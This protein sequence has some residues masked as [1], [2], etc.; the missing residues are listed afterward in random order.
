MVL[1]L[2]YEA[3][4]NTSPI[5]TCLLAATRD[6][7]I[8]AVNEAFI[9]NSGRRREDL[10]GLSVFAAFPGD[11]DDASD[12]GERAVRESLRRVLATGA[13][14]HLPVQR[15]PILVEHADGTSHYEER[16]WSAVSAPIFDTDG[17]VL[18]ITHSTTDIT[19]LVRIEAAAKEARSA[20]GRSSM[21]PW[22]SST[23]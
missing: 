17:Q 16:F 5:G 11:P 12:T 7:T 19:E 1:S 8:L 13:P 2:L 14:D 15:Y 9:K 18:C 22:T 10:V 20:S 21:P 23:A 3:N 6:A 4:F